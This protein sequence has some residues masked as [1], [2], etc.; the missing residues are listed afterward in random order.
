MNQLISEKEK[1]YIEHLS[2]LRTIEQKVKKIASVPLVEARAYKASGKAK[3]KAKLK[4]KLQK[5]V[6]TTI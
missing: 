2:F 4:P 1:S 6:S 3:A 5:Q